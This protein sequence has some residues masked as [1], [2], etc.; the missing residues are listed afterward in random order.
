M[1]LSAPS[2]KGIQGVQ[3]NSR[4][5]KGIPGKELE[6]IQ[7]NSREEVQGNSRE[8]KGSHAVFP[9][10]L[11]GTPG[12]SR[13]LKGTRSKEFKRTQGNLRELMKQGI[14]EFSSPPRNSQND[15]MN[16]WCSVF[17]W[18]LWERVVGF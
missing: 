5:F 12:N 8:L 4:G 9:E 11:K 15:P 13:E 3:G 16:V 10:E 18:N 6:G 17:F 14:H 7:G 1:L 2:P